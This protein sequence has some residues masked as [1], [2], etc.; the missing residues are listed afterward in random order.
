V[1][2]V[3]V[4]PGEETQALQALSINK[5]RHSKSVKMILPGEG[6]GDIAVIEGSSSVVAHRKEERSDIKPQQHRSTSLTSNTFSSDGSEFSRGSLQDTDCCASAVFTA[7]RE[8][9]DVRT[10]ADKLLRMITKEVMKNSLNG[11]GSAEDDSASDID[12]VAV[13][14]SLLR[15]ASLRGIFRQA[16]Q[17]KITNKC[18]AAEAKKSAESSELDEESAE[19]DPV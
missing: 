7:G 3:A 14:D 12:T 13:S 10:L 5:D 15:S 2:A 18:D 17:K 16:L 4:G 6:A 1:N 11:G 19:F 8:P 9:G